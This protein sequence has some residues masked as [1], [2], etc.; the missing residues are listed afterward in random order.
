MSEKIT[1]EVI[2]CFWPVC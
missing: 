2:Y 1:D